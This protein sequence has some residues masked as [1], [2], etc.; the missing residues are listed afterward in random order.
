MG[1]YVVVS[2]PPAAGKSTLAVPLAA[3]LDLPL[4]AK[5]T[6]KEALM[7]ILD[8][9]DVA[10]SRRL[11]R[12]SVEALMAV[13][14][15]CPTA[16]LESAWHRDAARAQLQALDAPIVE[17]FC[18]CDPAVVEQRYRARAATRPAGHF[19]GSR[20]TA[21]RAGT[22]SGVPIGGDW[23]LV[24]VRT[25]RLVDISALAAEI[26]HHLPNATLP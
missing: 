14:R 2:G 20:T 16:V 25:D 23:P 10:T 6:I 4:I 5:D 24:E 15:Q 17:V 18:R 19:D 21:E 13:A 12:A 26:R 22:F 9:P 1:F 3:E 11:G 8:V 7:R